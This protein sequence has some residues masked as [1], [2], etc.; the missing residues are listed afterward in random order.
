MAYSSTLHVGGPLM[1]DAGY[2][3]A[4]LEYAPASGVAGAS[5]TTGAWRTIPFDTERSDIDG[6]VSLS[7]NQ[8]TLGAGNY[9]IS[10]RTAH[11]P[12]ESA[13]INYRLRNITSAS[14]LAFRPTSSIGSTI[15]NMFE[16]SFT[17]VNTSTLEIQAFT[18]AGFAMGTVLTTGD[19]ECYASLEIF[20]SKDL[21]STVTI[22]HSQGSNLSSAI[23][24]LQHRENNGVAGQT[25]TANTWETL[26]VNHEDFDP[27]N[28]VTVDGA[29]SRFTLVAGVYE[30]DVVA[31]IGGAQTHNFRA[32]EV[33]NTGTSLSVAR[34]TSFRNNGAGGAYGTGVGAGTYG[35]KGQVRGQFSLSSSTTLSIRYM[36]HSTT[37]PVLSAP[38]SYQEIYHEFII[39]KL[40]DVV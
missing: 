4:R 10:F 9:R 29:N 38:S 11:D 31:D 34:L 20:K 6:I 40:K 27:E 8:F 15:G 17:L 32:A 28:L 16:C 36:C 19:N 23:A 7:T 2:S 30:I 33:L 24:V 3:Y 1:V 13:N 37:T 12:T 25:L 26:K 22:N 21:T 18:S 5:I 14:T 39:K 35:Y